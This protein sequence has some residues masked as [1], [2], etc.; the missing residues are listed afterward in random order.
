MNKLKYLTLFI[1]FF[2]QSCLDKEEPILPEEQNEIN[3]FV[4]GSLNSWYYWQNDEADLSDTR[5]SNYTELSRFIGQFT[6]PRDLFEELRY[7]ED[8][9]SWIVDDYDV[10]NQSFQGTSDSFGFEFSLVN[11]D[12]SILAY[13]EY[14]VPDGPADLAGIERGDIFDGINGQKMTFDNYIAL[15]SEDSYQINLVDVIDRNIID[16]NELVNLSKIT[17]TENPVFKYDVIEYG[18]LKIGYLVYNQFVYTFHRELNEAFQ[19]FTAEG[20]DELIVDLRYNRGGAVVTSA[21]LG[22]MIY[23]QGN[24]GQVFSVL[25]YNEKHSR[26]DVPFGFPQTLQVR[27]AN[28]AITSEENLFRTST[29]RVYFLTGRSSASASELVINGLKPYMDITVIG[30]TTVGKNEG[31]LTLYDSP[32]SDYLSEERANPNHKWALQPIVSKV[33]N[34]NGFGDYAEGLAPDIFVS[35]VDHFRDLKPLGDPEEAL[36]SVA[37][38]NITGIS[39]GR[40]IG[41][42]HSIQFIGSSK[43]QKPYSG[44]MSIE[45][46]Y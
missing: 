7:E 44:V 9:F 21:I 3:E 4:W 8:R 26:F 36:L 46:I 43:R 11:L 28:Y 14:V 16:R 45:G 12:G 39:S 6:N 2:I 40:K 22:S 38:E 17:L 19:R 13:V 42:D 23:G 37:L 30:D 41:R 27:G 34:A 24:S 33:V 32:E 5:F 10:L 35:E 29:D 1:L 25:E 31:S 18:G 20:I 15:L